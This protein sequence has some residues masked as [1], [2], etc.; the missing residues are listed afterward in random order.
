MTDK[1]TRSPQ[2]KKALSLQKDRRNGY[3]E[4]D[5]GSRKTI[6]AAKARSH[7]SLRHADKQALGDVD[8]ASEVVPLTLAKPAWK[9]S[10]DV[11]LGEVIAS[12]LAKR[13]RQ[14][15]RRAKMQKP[16]PQA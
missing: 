3:G 10:P 2:E 14:V 7:R 13:V 15:K 4:S 5:K 16:G 8:A 6:P 1:K 9:K 11:P 12:G